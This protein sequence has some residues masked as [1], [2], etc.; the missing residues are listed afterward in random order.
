MPARE[1]AVEIGRIRGD[2]FEVWRTAFAEVRVIRGKEIEVEGVRQSETIFRCTFDYFDVEGV[3]DTMALRFEGRRL[4][5]KQVRED[6]V[7]REWTVI[8]GIQTAPSDG[9]TGPGGG[10]PGSGGG[11]PPPAGG[12]GAV[13]D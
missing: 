12:G 1:N 9:S 7:A 10:D 3:D 5:I 13:W 4:D 11:D 6:F 8:E 2:D